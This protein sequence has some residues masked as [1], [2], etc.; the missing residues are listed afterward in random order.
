LRALRDELKQDLLPGQRA[1]LQERQAEAGNRFMDVRWTIN[2]MC[3]ANPILAR[4]EFASFHSTEGQQMGESVPRGIA[5]AVL[6]AGQEF[7]S[8]V[9]GVVDFA[10]KLFDF[11]VDFFIPPSRPT[12]EMIHARQNANEAAAEAARIWEQNDAHQDYNLAEQRR[13]QGEKDSQRDYYE[14]QQPERILEDED[15]LER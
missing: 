11:V 6:G 4:S 10:A 7:G 9:S 13:V 8:L 15:E 14:K 3:A 2:E 12:P 1:A 5:N